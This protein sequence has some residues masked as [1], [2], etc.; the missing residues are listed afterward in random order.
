MYDPN[1]DASRF[2]PSELAQ[3]PDGSEFTNAVVRVHEHMLKHPSDK[4]SRMF[5]RSQE[6]NADTA[7]ALELEAG[8]NAAISGL[9]ESVV[10]QYI[11]PQG[12]DLLAVSKLHEA[13]REV[14]DELVEMVGGDK[15]HIA[16]V[17][18]DQI[19]R[20]AHAAVEELYPGLSSPQHAAG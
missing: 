11:E 10:A 5:K 16:T 17:I 15:R 4:L 19:A 8:V 7:E 14:V 6:N 3:G 2:M 13:K 9:V 1:N 20:D 12:V 18:A